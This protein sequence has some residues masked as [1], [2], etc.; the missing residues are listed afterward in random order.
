[1]KKFTLNIV[2]L[3]MATLILINFSKTHAQCTNTLPY[4]L[5]I[6]PTSGTVTISTCSYQ[7]EYS[8]LQSVIAATIYQC[9]IVGGGYITIHEGTP[10]G[11]VI[12]S[13]ASPLQWN[14]TVAG[15]YFAHWNVDASCATAA[16]CMV[17][18]MTYISPA[19]PCGNPVAAGTTVSTPAGACPGQAISLSLNGVTIGTGLTYQWQSSANGTTWTDIT[20]ATNANYSLIQTANTYYQCIVTCSAGTP[21]TSTPILVN[22]NS[23]FSCYCSTINAGGG[24]CMM[25]NIQIGSINNN[26]AT[27]NPIASPFYTAFALNT[28]LAQGATYSLSVAIDAANVYTGAIVSVWIDWNQNGQYEASEWQQ[29]GVNINSGTIASININVPIGIP[30]GTTGMRIRSRGAGNPN[31]ATDACTDM[32]S[33]ETEDYTV[34]IM[35]VPT[36]PQPQNFSLVQAGLTNALIQWTAGGAETQWEVQYGLQGFTPGTGTTIVTSSNPYTINGLTGNTF[37]EVYIRALCGGGDTSY[38]APVLAFQT[39]NQAQYLD[40]DSN[41]PSTGFIDISATGTPLNTWDDSNQGITLPWSWLVQGNLVNDISVGNNGGLIFNSLNS[42]LYYNI[43]GEGM[44]PFVQDLNTPLDNIYYE[45]IGNAPN[46]K[47]V[48]MWSDL[49]HFTWPAGTDGATFEIIYEETSNEFYYVYDDV[50][51]GDTW[52]DNGAD[53]EIGVV[54]PNQTIQVSMDDAAYLSSNS[55]IHFYYTNCPKPQS[56]NL[57]YVNS[58]EGSFTWTPSIANETNWTVIY[59]PT[60]FDPTTNGTS[61][62]SNSPS[63]TLSNLNQLTQYDV[64][65]YADCS[66]GLQSL[67]LFG[68]F[69]TPPYCSNPTAMFNATAVDSIFAS[70]TWSASSPSYPS[71]GFNLQYGTMDFPL[72]SGTVQAVDNNMTDTIA[73]AAFIASEVIDVYVQAV[74]GV[75]TSQYV[76]PFTV[77]LPLTNDLACG[78]D[79]IPVNGATHYFD[80]TGATVDVTEIGIAPPASG[81]QTTTGWANN[82]L[83]LTSWFS[84]IAPNSG[85]VRINCTASAYNGQMAIYSGWDCNNLT[86]FNLVAANDDEIGG[87]SLAPNFTICGL[88]PGQSYYM[89]QDGFNAL[90]GIHAIAIN[91]IVLNAGIAGNMMNVCYGDSVNLFNGI[92][93]NDTGGTWTQQIPTLGLQDS[94]FNTAGLA[95]VIFNFT[96][97]MQDGCA[98]DNVNAQVHVYPP[99]SAGNDGQMTVCKNEPFNLLMGLS[100]N[101]DMNGDWYNPSNQLMTSPNDVASFIPGQFNYDYITGNG[102]CPDDTANIL[103]IVSANCDYLSLEELGQHIAMYPNPTSNDVTI[104]KGIELSIE[105]IIISDLNGKV[106][107]TITE[108]LDMNSIKLSFATYETGVYFI[109]IST[110]RGQIM[111]RIVKQ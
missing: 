66:V 108:G 104:D 64:Y 35:P 44:F 84:F 70:W 56:F 18:T 38:F 59:G 83:N 69:F 47:F 42:W 46:R 65:I 63:A 34:T 25:N 41:C 9:E 77:T 74:C 102:I 28:I 54:T 1:M 33:G 16:N 85:A 27:T 58:S 51:M 89:M 95:P 103:V 50:M 36:C 55:C 4:A 106:L 13:G 22:M 49:A 82:A 57:S 14:S 48:I 76:G 5:A 97:T 53:A 96:Y 87:S 75:D 101:V 37:Y 99:S 6:A 40:W 2:S 60:G 21:A 23:F 29:V 15:T 61:V 39:F 62:P 45:S 79:V 73:N 43:N 19:S 52:W 68:T 86:T 8:E 98:I 26:T 105:S 110:P 31:G 7:E 10:S 94:I 93:G 24:G 91:E 72:Y 11:P 107:E 12:A 3:I 80:N 30:L 90:E 67:G 17:T 92:S 71:T 78:A 111:N 100:G 20:G 88:I 109:K 32:G 81:A